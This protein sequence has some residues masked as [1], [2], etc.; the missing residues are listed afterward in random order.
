MVGLGTLHGGMHGQGGHHVGRLA[1]Y[2]R[3]STQNLV[4][5]DAEAVLDLAR[6]QFLKRSR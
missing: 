6:A 4:F 2:S 1:V 5:V 3:S